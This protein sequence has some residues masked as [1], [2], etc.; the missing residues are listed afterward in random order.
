MKK[1][2]LAFA[3]AATLVAAQA[4]HA[5]ITASSSV[6]GGAPANATKYDLNSPGG[7]AGDLTVSLSGGAQL[8][9]TSSSIG[10]KPYFSGANDTGFGNAGDGP[11]QTQ[12][13]TTSTGTATLTF[14]TPLSYL[15]FVWGSVDDYNTIT[16]Y[17]SGNAIPLATFTPPAAGIPLPDPAG[18]QNVVGTYWVNFLS[19]TPFDKVVLTS[20]KNAFEIDNIATAVPEPSTYLAGALLLLP[21]GAGAFRAM[22]SRKES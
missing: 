2:Q 5:T 15:G 4:A 19:D 11:D 18:D 1:I 7:S 12:Y 10:A 16:F 20:T 14:D 8:V 22:R 13:L 17:K 3:A 6:G 21:F 9:T